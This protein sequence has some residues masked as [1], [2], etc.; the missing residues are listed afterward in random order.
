MTSRAKDECLSGFGICV[1]RGYVVLLMDNPRGM[2]CHQ[3]HHGPS[4]K[5]LAFPERFTFPGETS[6]KK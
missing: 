5:L 6:S 2:R 3:L 1:F 4:G